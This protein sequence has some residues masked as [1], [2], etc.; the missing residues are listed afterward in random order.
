MRCNRIAQQQPSLLRRGG[1]LHPRGLRDRAQRGGDRRA[2]ERHFGRYCQ[3]REALPAPLAAGPARPRLPA[4]RAREPA[5]SGPTRQAGTPGGARDRGDRRYG[6]QDSRRR[7]ACCAGTPG[8][9]SEPACGRCVDVQVRQGSGVPRRRLRHRLA[10]VRGGSLSAGRQLAGH[11][12]QGEH[13]ATA[14]YG[15]TPTI[16]TDTLR[17]PSLRFLPHA[18]PPLAFLRSRCPSL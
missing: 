3:E 9:A 14:R 5:D 6:R 16:I 2:L 17:P 4:R 13:H 8:A 18:S 15:K 1:Y 12:V 11:Y 10:A 7:D